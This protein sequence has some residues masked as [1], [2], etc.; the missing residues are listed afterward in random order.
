MLLTNNH[1]QLWATCCRVQA[2]IDHPLKAIYQLFDMRGL[3]TH[4]LFSDLQSMSIEE[5]LTLNERNYNAPYPEVEKFY[6]TF[7]DSKRSIFA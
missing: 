1:E 5:L 6:L 4:P 7:C 3:L 2:E